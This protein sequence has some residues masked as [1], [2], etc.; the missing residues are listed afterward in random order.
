MMVFRRDDVVSFL[1]RDWAA[2]RRR[3]NEHW[4]RPRSAKA[5]LKAADALWRHMKS[6]R[7]EWPTPGDRAADFQHHIRVAHLLE[8][9]A[10]A[11]PKSTRR[12]RR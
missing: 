1:G 10:C 9:A 11:F 3:K 5:R 8:K 4:A 12:R 6:L 2:S 7:P